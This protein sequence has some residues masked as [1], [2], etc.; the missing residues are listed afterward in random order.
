MTEWKGI[1]ASSGYAMGRAFLLQD[2]KVGIPERILAEEEIEPELQRLEETVDSAVEQ[3]EAIQESSRDK[4]G[5]EQLEIFSFHIA[6]LQGSDYVKSMAANIKAEALNAEAAVRQAT[7]KF[8]EMFE[9][10]DNEYMRER[11]A[12]FRDVGSRLLKIL[13]G[14]PDVA[15]DESGE[16]LILVAHELT[17]SD[18]AQLSR[19]KVSGFVTNVGGKTSHTAIM[20]RSMEIPAVVG[21]NGILESVRP[22]DFVIIDGN[23]GTVWINPSAESISHYQDKQKQF[24]VQQLELRTLIDAPSVTADGRRIELAANIGNP[25]DAHHARQIGAEGIGLYRT[26]FLYMD[27][28]DLPSEEEQFRAYR[29][30]AEAF[31]MESPIVIRTL[32]IGGDKELPYLGLPKEMNPFLGYRAIRICLDRTDIFKVQLRAILRASVHG[33]IK[34]MF[35]MIS[36]LHELR[37]AKQVLEEAKQELDE[38][39]IP[40]NRELEVGMM[41]EIPSSAIIADQLA[42]EVNF[43]SIGTNDL[44][45]YTLAVDRM[46]ESVSYLYEPFE[47]AVL[48][49]IHM[50][51]QAAHKEGKWVGM[52]GEMAGDLTAIPILVGMGLDELSMSASSILP[53]R[54]L[55]RRSNVQEWQ[56]MTEKVLQMDTAQE[57]KAYMG[58]AFP[59]IHN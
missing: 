40:F 31:G 59:E 7:G 52:C 21:L 56:R 19:D 34:L 44:I 22:G 53:A 30:V 39:N 18:T 48:R 32:D 33:N 47:P 45:Q 26:E 35:P 49:L 50:V 55:I 17:P 16:K 42:K 6:L 28:E 12:D 23:E 13:S 1:A 15:W 9:N 36:T 38:A 14:I 2:D 43:F 5:E 37:T 41:I 4:L 46:N 29:E 54:S 58:L 10:I 8:V 11:A 3:L 51:V 24:N 57:I 20:A 27:R 25:H